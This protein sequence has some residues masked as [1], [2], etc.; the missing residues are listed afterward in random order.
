LALSDPKKQREGFARLRNR[1]NFCHNTEVLET[2]KGSLI[3]LRKTKQ[4]KS[5]RKYLP[6]EHCLSMVLARNLYRRTLKCPLKKHSDATVGRKLVK[7]SAHCMLRGAVK[8]GKSHMSAKFQEE[9][10]QSMRCDKVSE[11][12]KTD[13]LIIRFGECLHERLGSQRAHDISQRM[14][15]LAR[16]LQKVNA[17]RQERITLSQCLTVSNF[18]NIV[19][20]T[21]SLCEVF[22][23]P[24][25]RPLFRI[26]SL[27]L[28]LGHS[29]KSCAEAKRG[30]AVRASDYVTVQEVDDFLFLHSSE[31]TSRISSASLASLK[32]RKYNNPELLPVTSDLVKLKE[33][34]TRQIALLSNK[35]EQSPSCGTWR[36]L[37]E[38]VYTRLIIFNKRRCGETAKLVLNAFLDRP[39][40]EEAANDEIMQSLQPLEQKLMQRYVTLI[41]LVTAY[42]RKWL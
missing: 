27:G 3:C 18:D 2:R 13:D 28:K 4:I 12:C 39:R 22:D 10:L 40:W 35:L 11:V 42:A 1:G 36:S 19:K 9:I 7:R 41:S 5:P 21:R 24:S 30:V 34:Q 20:A 29:L 33:Y 26:P 16:L 32:Y 17:E 6:C 38:Q 37:M 15:L 8:G 31:W 23:D 14:R 25:G